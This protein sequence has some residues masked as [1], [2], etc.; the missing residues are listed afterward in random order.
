M[1]PVIQTADTM[2]T[3]RR[4]V[5]SINFSED[6]FAFPIIPVKTAFMT[7]APSVLTGTNAWV[8]V[9][10]DRATFRKRL[11]DK[12]WALYAAG[13]LDN[14]DANGTTL[15]LVYVKD[16]GSLVT[17]GTPTTVPGG[18][19]FQKIMLGPVDVFGSAGVPAGESVP[20]LGLTAQK[21]AGANGAL[22]GWCLWLRLL[23]P[24][25]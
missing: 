15:T 10:V 12:R 8:G 16:D 18:A 20:M 17:L 9:A 24:T 13:A 2:E 4:V 6:V 19:G 1:I 7:A 5:H 3:L 11:K 25:A 23:P 21:A 22:T 14:G